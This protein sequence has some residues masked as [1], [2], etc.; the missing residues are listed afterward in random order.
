MTLRL[1]VPRVGVHGADDAVHRRIEEIGY[2]ADLERA[3]LRGHLY[4]LL[5]LCGAAGDYYEAADEPRI[6]DEQAPCDHRPEEH[7]A[8]QRGEHGVERA[9]RRAGV[10]GRGDY[11]DGGVDIDDEREYRPPIPRPAERAY[12]EE[13]DRE[14]RRLIQKRIEHQL[15]HHHRVLGKEADALDVFIYRAEPCFERGLD[16]LDYVELAEYPDEAADRRLEGLGDNGEHDYRER[17]Q[18]IH[19]QADVC[20]V[21]EYGNGLHDSAVRDEHDGA[22]YDEGD[23]LSQK[24]HGGSGRARARGIA[25][26]LEIMDLERLTARAEGRY[27]IVIL[28]EQGDLERAFAV[29]PALREHKHAAVLHIVREHG[30]AE[31]EHAEE[32]ENQL[33]IAYRNL[34]N[35][36]RAGL[37]FGKSNKADDQ[38]VYQQRDYEAYAPFFAA[39]FLFQFYLHRSPQFIFFILS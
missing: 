36:P 31:A 5:G 34:F 2:E 13:G 21:I 26:L 15:Y 35:I 18:R 24:S 25:A 8:L 3:L 37:E 38:H 29:E 7:P 30:D 6:I 16:V 12:H 32:Q 4:A 14:Y 19:Q 28:A 27:V 23:L 9:L 20:C 39:V 1:K 22:R 11:R 33:Y 10:A 17:E